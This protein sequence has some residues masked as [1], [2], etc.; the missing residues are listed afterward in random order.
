MRNFLTL[1]LL[2]ISVFLKAQ[3]ESL[4]TLEIIGRAKWQ[5]VPDLI[6]IDYNLNVKGKQQIDVIESL[7]VQTAILTDKLA[8]LGYAKANLKLSDISIEINYDYT[9][10]RAKKD[11]YSGFQVMVM[12]IPFNKEN[13][14]TIIEKIFDDKLK[15]LSLSFQLSFSDSLRQATRNKLIEI[16]IENA[17][18]SADCISKKSSV[19]LKR[20]MKIEYKDLFFKSRYS[21]LMP[22]PPPPY[23]LM[24]HEAEG[25]YELAITRQLDIKE[26]DVYEEVVIVWEIESAL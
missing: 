23:D 16:A 5:V 1:L 26:E 15:D 12:Q 11:G 8:E 3:V 21:Q 20:I 9:S 22:P 13:I 18:K 24:F 2:G 10:S 17:E 14:S 6:T 25:N 4:P 7:N 19:K